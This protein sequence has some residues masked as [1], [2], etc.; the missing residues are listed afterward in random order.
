[1]NDLSYNL[2]KPLNCN[3]LTI[4]LKSPYI[5]WYIRNCAVPCAHMSQSNYT[6]ERFIFSFCTQKKTVRDTIKSCLEFIT[7]NVIHLMKSKIQ[8][9]VV[10]TKYRFYE[11]F[12]YNFRKSNNKYFTF[13]TIFSTVLGERVVKCQ[14]LV[15][16]NVQGLGL[17]EKVAMTDI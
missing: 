16:L 8:Y 10:G 15:R 14:R 11:S 13:L 9:K 12:K 17:S 5:Q 7:T 1:M 2:L 4:S 3:K 6:Y